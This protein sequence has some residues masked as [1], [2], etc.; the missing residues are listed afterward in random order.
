MKKERRKKKSKSGS[1]RSRGRGQPLRGPQLPTIGQPTAAGSLG[2]VGKHGDTTRG[3]NSTPYSVVGL[4]QLLVLVF[5][6]WFW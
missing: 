3:V 5:T 4:A 6:R 1:G 2:T